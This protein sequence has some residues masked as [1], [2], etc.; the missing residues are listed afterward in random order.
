MDKKTLILHS[1]M[2]QFAEKG[3][4]QATIQDIADAAGI[5][6]GGIYFYFKSKEELVHAVFVHY[7]D[8]LFK[9]VSEASARYTPGSKEGLIQQVMLQ[10]SELSS[11]QSF[12]AIFFRGQ[13][14]VNEEIRQMAIHIRTKFFI[15]FRD[16]LIKVYGPHIEPH[17]FDLS[18]MMS[19]LIR[20]YMG[21]ILLNET[22]LPLRELSEF[23]V[24]RLEDAIEGILKS[25]QAPILTTALMK[26]LFPDMDIMEG[27]TTARRLYSAVEALLRRFDAAPVPEDERFALQQ[28]AEVIKEEIRQHKP[29]RIVLEGMAALLYGR[30]SEQEQWPEF[31]EINKIIAE[32]A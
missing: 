15:L 14:D 26:S 6:K 12:L 30:K 32:F 23:I 22:K 20:E 11:H 28:A 3:Y 29:R 27:T 18:A 8:Q 24:N 19:S 4:H 5:A 21:F 25:N 17:A 9:S 31:E 16:Q 1:A 7:N 2:K 10:F 13:V